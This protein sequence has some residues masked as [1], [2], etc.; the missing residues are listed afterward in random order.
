MSSRP[1][2]ARLRCDVFVT[3]ASPIRCSRLRRCRGADR[4]IRPC[5]VCPCL[6]KLATKRIFIL[7]TTRSYSIGLPSSLRGGVSGDDP[8]DGAGS[9]VPRLRREPQRGRSGTPPIRPYGLTRAGRWP[10]PVPLPE[11]AARVPG[12]K[13]PRRSA[14]RASRLQRDGPRFAHAVVAPRT[15]DIREECACRRSATPSLGDGLKEEAR[16]GR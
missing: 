10:A 6:I 3:P 8:D 1:E 12:R 5:G 13:S 11:A 16:S 2:P 9:G 7:T 4:K 14:E 15:R